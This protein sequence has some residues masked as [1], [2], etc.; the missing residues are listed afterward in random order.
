MYYMAL[1]LSYVPTSKDCMSG[2]YCT[3]YC[4]LNSLTV[5]SGSFTD[6]CI[7]TEAIE[8]SSQLVLH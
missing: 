1:G 8:L 2:Y 3:N 6:A 4:K 7:Y 5:K